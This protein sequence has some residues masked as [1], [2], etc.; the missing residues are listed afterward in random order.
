MLLTNQVKKIIMDCVCD[1]RLISSAL[2]YVP[3]VD[4]VIYSN[5]IICSYKLTYLMVGLLCL[6]LIIFNILRFVGI[7]LCLYTVLL[8]INFCVETLAWYNILLGIIGVI[9]FPTKEHLLCKRL[10]Y[11]VGHNDE[12]KVIDKTVHTGTLYWVKLSESFIFEA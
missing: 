3:V 12:M 9:Q 4:T 11:V 8:V 2:L 1:P 6:T 10:L 7:Q 5:I